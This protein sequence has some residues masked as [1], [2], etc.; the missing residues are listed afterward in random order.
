MTPHGIPSTLLV[1]LLGAALA[2][3]P[4][5]EGAL[6]EENEPTTADDEDEDEE[7]L[8]A[9]R[10][11]LAVVSSVVPG[12]VVHGSGHM[13]AGDWE[14][15]T[16]LLAAEGVGLAMAVTGLV[17][18]GLTGASSELIIPLTWTVIE[19]GALLVI[20][21]LAD[22]Y[23]VSAPAG[24]TGLPLVRAQ[25]LRA[26]LGYRYVHNPIFDY[27]NFSVV[28]GEWRWRALRLAPEAWFAVDDDNWRLRTVAAWRIL[29]PRPDRTAEDGSFLELE[30]GYARHRYGTEGFTESTFEASFGGRLDLER[31]SRSLR[32]SFAESSLGLAMGVYSYDDL[33]NEGTEM[34]LGRFAFGFYTGH[35]RDGWGET[36]IYYNH[37]HD[38]YAAGLKMPGP[39]SGIG[40][41]FG[42]QSTFAVWEGLGVKLHAESGSAH[43]VGASMLYQMGGHR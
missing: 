27:Q 30:G 17:G 28:G 32:G 12:V 9:G 31:V 35:A 3:A 26:E 16:L 29:G 34:L 38:G 7:E 13:V 5:H 40:G 1:T 14:T 20:P 23:G 43:V 2:F 15:G 41:H 33:V 19:G 18:L 36:S 39:G 25:D 11:T 10:R 21:A 42:L 8:S 22:I 4:L 6:A 37:R 24:G